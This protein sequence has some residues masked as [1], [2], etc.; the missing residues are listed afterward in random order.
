MRRHN[1]HALTILQAKSAVSR[2]RTS[3]PKGPAPAVCE[4]CTP[5]GR[6]VFHGDIVMRSTGNRRH[7]RTEGTA[8]RL[9]AAFAGALIAALWAPATVYAAAWHRLYTT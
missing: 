7:M 4:H 9:T 8:R 5:A 1:H 3:P 6:L 2:L